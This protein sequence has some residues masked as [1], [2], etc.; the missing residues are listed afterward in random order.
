MRTTARLAICL[1]LVLLC[2]SAVAQKRMSPLE[3]QPS[4]RHRYELRK[5]RFE[6]GPSF[7]FSVNRSLRQA[8]L[9]GAKLEYHLN[10]W[11]SFGADFGYGLNVNTGLANELKNQ[12]EG[13]C[14]GPASNPAAH[15]DLRPWDEHKKHFSNITLAGDIR[16]IFTPITGKMGVFSKLFIAYDLYVFAGL[17]MAL[18]S[19][20][21][22]GA[23]S[24]V[25]NVTQGFRVG[26]AFGFGI[27]VFFT[28]FFSMGIE[29]KDIAFSDNESG[30]D[31]TRGL[32]DAELESSRS[33]GQGILIDK[34][35]KQFTNH[36]FVGLNF[37]FFL[38]TTVDVSW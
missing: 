29:I 16:G 18:L 34:K 23:S 25:D 5:G 10:D 9:L 37:T 14:V 4:I 22:E 31:L 36:W 19:N 33:G 3:D 38:P 17:G 15:D 8:I 30:G 6:L 28:K 2:G 7:G 12:C 1:G 21:L 26:P 11:L 32:A 13:S 24:D 35:D 27:H 20:T